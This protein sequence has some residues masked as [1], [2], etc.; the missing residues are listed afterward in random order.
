[1]ESTEAFPNGCVV[2]GPMVSTDGLPA[3]LV[4]HWFPSHFLILTVVRS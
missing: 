4:L 1:M 2:V 3:G